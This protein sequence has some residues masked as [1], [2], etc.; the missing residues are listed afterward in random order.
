MGTL[1][2]P[3]PG[4]SERDELE[5][6]QQELRE[7]RGHRETLPRE[8]AELALQVEQLE[9]EVRSLRD[10]VDEARGEWK[11]PAPSLPEQL[12]SPF[13]V[14]PSRRTAYGRLRYSFRTVL[15][16]LLPFAYVA[17]RLHKANEYSLFLIAGYVLFSFG[18][19]YFMQGHE[20]DD[21]RRAWSFDE[22]GFFPVDLAEGSGKVLYAE[23][24]QVEV[25]QG[26]LER[27]FGFGTVRV[28]WTPAVPTSLGK[29]RGFSNRVIDIP[30]L[31][32][33]KRLAAW[34]EEQK[35]G[36]HVG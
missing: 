18:L 22:Q 12:V 30:L 6:L 29:A 9:R 21:G 24:Q 3:E 7:V 14:S 32:E 27:L 36:A 8:N 26:W 1:T 35:A 33:P 23:L 20:D 10:T 15:P 34:L 25:R 5:R 4:R 19:I 28:T 13:L 11:Q 17:G 2:R 31:D 16:T